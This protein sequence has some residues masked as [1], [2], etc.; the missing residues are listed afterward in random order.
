[1]WLD[2]HTGVLWFVL[3]NPI[4]LNMSV[5][6]L[7][8]PFCLVHIGDFHVGILWFVIFNPIRLSMSIDNLNI[9]LMLVH[10]GKHVSHVT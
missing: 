5:G 3:F 2:S 9:S 6:N 1:M 7:K 10:V 8:I 4:S